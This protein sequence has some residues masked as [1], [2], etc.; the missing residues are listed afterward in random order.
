VYRVDGGHYSGDPTGDT[1]ARV[2]NVREDYEDR[3]L[4]APVNDTL[5]VRIYSP[6]HL[7]S[8]AAEI[9]MSGGRFITARISDPAYRDTAGAVRLRDYYDYEIV[10]GDWAGD[11]SRGHL[12]NPTP[13]AVPAPAPEPVAPAP[14]YVPVDE[15]GDWPEPD[16][17][18]PAPAPAPVLNTF[19]ARFQNGRLSLLRFDSVEELRERYP[20]VRVVALGNDADGWAEI[21]EEDYA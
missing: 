20:D 2:F 1:R 7:R 12:F 19:R 10:S 6:A 9:T 3:P 11:A 8:F 5:P 16:A 21:D 4:P 13:V 17:P 14:A 18:A 15:V